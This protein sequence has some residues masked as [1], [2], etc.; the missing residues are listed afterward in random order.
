MFWILLAHPCIVCVPIGYI[1]ISIE[2]YLII[3]VENCKSLD[4]L[5]FHHENYY[6]ILYVFLT[7]EIWISNRSLAITFY[8]FWYIAL[9]WLIKKNSIFYLYDVWFVYALENYTGIC[10]LYTNS[11]TKF[12]CRMNL[13]FSRSK[14]I[15]VCVRDWKPL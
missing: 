1:E 10:G 9:W 13:F 7:F 8:V 15:F 11:K 6:I 14:R 5:N 4:S 3:S 2:M 12:F